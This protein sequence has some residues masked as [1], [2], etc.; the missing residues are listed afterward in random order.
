MITGAQRDKLL[1]YIKEKY[2]VKGEFL[3][4]IL[5][6]YLKLNENNKNNLNAEIMKITERLSE[7]QQLKFAIY[8]LENEI[9]SSEDINQMAKFQ[10]KQALEQDK[11]K[12]FLPRFVLEQLL[13]IVNVDTNTMLKKIC[14]YNIFFVMI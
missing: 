5:M 8:I 13:N 9:S 3:E 6:M 4:K 7:E 11:I 2:V 1:R 10:I 14:F 12:F